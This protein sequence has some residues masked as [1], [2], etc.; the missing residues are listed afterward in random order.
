M[1]IKLLTKLR[2]STSACQFM[3]W[4]YFLL[5]AA[6][7]FA[8][9]GN[10]VEERIKTVVDVKERIV[11]KDLD[12]SKQE[13]RETQTF[14]ENGTPL[15][16]ERYRLH[17]TRVSKEHQQDKEHRAEEERVSIGYSK[18]QY[19]ISGGVSLLGKDSIYSFDA[20][21]RV[22]N[23][24]IFG[25]FGIIIPQNAFRLGDTTFIIGVRYEF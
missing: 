3:R 22:G 6:I 24:P 18:P 7:S 15:K 8:L 12:T 11:Y 13:E 9:A 20:G 4:G 25:T 23:L 1:P 2:P 19:S 17:T 14:T 16:I 10:R 5:G 21:V